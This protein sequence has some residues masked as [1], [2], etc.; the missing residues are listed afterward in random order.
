MPVRS[1][2]PSATRIGV[3]LRSMIDAGENVALSA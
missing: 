1:S 2:R 3:S